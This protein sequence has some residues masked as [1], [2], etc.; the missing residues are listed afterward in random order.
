MFNTNLFLFILAF[1]S[2]PI[3]TRKKLFKS[4]RRWLPII[5]PLQ[6]TVLFY[7]VTRFHLAGNFRYHFLFVLRLRLK[8]FP[9]LEIWRWYIL[10][11]FSENCRPIRNWGRCIFEYLSLPTCSLRPLRNRTSFSHSPSR[12]VPNGWRWI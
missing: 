8:H 9:V 7:S 2:S 12:G 11:S 5:R 10:S 4:T 1:R 3:T 6:Q